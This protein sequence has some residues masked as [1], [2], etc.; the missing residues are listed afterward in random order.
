M[1]LGPVLM[2]LSINNETLRVVRISALTAA[3]IFTGVTAAADDSTIAKLANPSTV[4]VSWITPVGAPNLPKHCLWTTSIECGTMVP[5]DFDLKS[6]FIASED[7]AALIPR[8]CLWTTSEACGTSAPLRA[9]SE[10]ASTGTKDESFPTDCMFR[11][12]IACGNVNE[13]LRDLLTEAEAAAYDDFCKREYPICLVTFPP[14]TIVVYGEPLD[15]NDITDPTSSAAVAHRNADPDSGVASVTNQARNTRQQQSQDAQQRRARDESDRPSNSTNTDPDDLPRQQSAPPT[16]I[17]SPFTHTPLGQPLHVGALHPLGAPTGN[18]KTTGAYF[19]L[20][21]V[22]RNGRYV[23]GGFDE[24]LNKLFTAATQDI[25]YYGE[26][27]MFVSHVTRTDGNGGVVHLAGTDALGNRFVSGYVHLKDIYVIHGQRVTNNTRIG[28][29]YGE[30]TIFT[31]P[32]AGEKH[33]HWKLFVNDVRSDP[34]RTFFR[35]L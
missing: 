4:D 27:E 3:A 19:G 16:R 5:F 1:K 20:T 8:H 28:S 9:A 23:H 26:I 11:T 24:T 33:V 6:P 17:K 18:G 32:G 12:S 7:E 29:G 34:L 22:N 30:G 14:D 35:A 13:E 31:R 15:D 21:R 2:K 25:V 10:I